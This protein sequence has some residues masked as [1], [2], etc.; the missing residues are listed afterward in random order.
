MNGT[1]LARFEP[2]KS[3]YIQRFK[4]TD[5]QSVKVA[6]GKHPG[7]KSSLI[8]DPDRRSYV[9]AHRLTVLG[10][11]AHE[12][13]RKTSDHSH[14]MGFWPVTIEE[15]LARSS[16]VRSDQMAVAVFLASATPCLSARLNQ[17]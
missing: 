12:G 10:R 15:A 5:R 16:S 14:G 6:E 3:Y 2:H 7:S 11:A 9:W 8:M 17:L 13:W 1:V 4:G